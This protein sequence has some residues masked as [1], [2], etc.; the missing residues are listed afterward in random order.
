MR[1]L[2]PGLPRWTH[3]DVSP[4]VHG[5]AQHPF[6][7]SLL[8]AEGNLLAAL[9]PPLALFTLHEDEEAEPVSLSAGSSPRDCVLPPSNTI[10]SFSQLPIVGALFSRFASGRSLS[11]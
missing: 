9:T 2:F 11:I 1:Q 4:A 3:R 5:R 6:L 7:F 10:H 8:S